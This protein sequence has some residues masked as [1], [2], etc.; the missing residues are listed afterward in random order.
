MKVVI[1]AG[2][3]GTR[4]GTLTQTIPKPLVRIGGIPIIE[5]IITSFRRYGF[6]D[7]IIPL[8]YKGNEIKRYFLNRNNE[9][10]DI[11]IDFEKNTVEIL[12][13]NNSD[14]KVTLIDTGL[15]TKT[16][17][18][19]KRLSNYIVDGRFMLTYGDGISDVN[20]NKLVQFHQSNQKIL[21][22]TVVRPPARFGEIQ[23]KDK[24]ITDFQEKSQIGSGYINGGFMIAEPELLNYIEGDNEMLEQGPM[25][26]L[27]A[28]KEVAGYKHDG[29]WKCMD[30][31]KDVSEL[32]AMWVENK[33]YE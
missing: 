26:R 6:N 7:F 10:N 3:Y 16:G 11:K 15:D 22:L 29:F 27:V 14:I 17:G 21:T 31:P 33:F 28:L 13:G 9:L 12:T 25:E 4:L 18:R 24:I 30:T 5:H 32:E 20:L 8:G 23:L 1:L 19:I 2:G